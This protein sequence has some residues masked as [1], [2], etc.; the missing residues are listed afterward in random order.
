MEKTLYRSNKDRMIAGVCGGLAHYFKVDPV[1]VRLI[2]ILCIFAGGLG[3]IA[4]IILAIVV[5][6]E[7][8]QSIEPAGTI[9][10]NIQ[11]MKNTAETIGK[12]I[13]STFTNSEKTSQP[14]SMVTVKE[15]VHTRRGMLIFGAIILIVG[16]IALLSTLGSLNWGWWLNGSYLWPVILIAIGLLLIFVRRK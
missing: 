3:I 8:S 12:D 2:F 6:S 15:E 14:R 1:I 16:I 10:E 9:R 7:N 5:P 4:Y 11:D 13:H